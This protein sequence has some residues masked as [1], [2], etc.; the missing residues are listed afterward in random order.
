[1]SV[2]TLLLVVLVGI[3]FIFNVYQYLTQR[4]ALRIAEILYIMSRHVREKA[5]QVKRESKDVEILEAHLFGIATS[6]R[7]LLRSL[8]RNESTLGADPTIDL[9]P[10]NGA[11]KMDSESLLRLADN[12]LFAVK[13][14]NPTANWDEIVDRSLDKF[15]EKV[16]TLERAAVK[17][18]MSVVAKQNKPNGTLAFSIDD[19]QQN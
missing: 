14:E 5:A 1:M 11:P 19:P 18:I 2:A 8:G 15:E 12:I 6:A 4:S 10:T 3:L 17:R 9:I 7:S 16:P 13:E